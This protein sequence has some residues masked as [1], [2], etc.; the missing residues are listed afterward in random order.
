MALG[1][2]VLILRFGYKNNI[3]NFFSAITVL[4]NCEDG[5]FHCL[6]SFGLW[7]YFLFHV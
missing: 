7:L 6:A 1:T 2:K 3:F 4:V 5:L